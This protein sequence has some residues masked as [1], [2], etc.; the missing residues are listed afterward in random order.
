VARAANTG[1]SCFVDQ[2]G[3]LHEVSDWW[4]PDARRR[5]VHLNERLTF[6]VRNGDLVG[7]VAVLLSPLLLLFVLVRS[8]RQRSAHR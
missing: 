1:I 8:I 3:D 6:F 5:T 2:R 4:V 7:R